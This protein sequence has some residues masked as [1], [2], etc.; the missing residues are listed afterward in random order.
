VQGVQE[1]PDYSKVSFPNMPALDLRLVL[2]AAHPQEVAF[3][4][5]L[6]ALDP[7]RRLGALEALQLDYF[8]SAPLPAPA[9]AV[10]VPL[11]IMGKAAHAGGGVGK[12]VA[13]V[14]SFLRDVVDTVVLEEFI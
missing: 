14:E 12:P 5:R 11:R 10:H 3:L 13:S 8:Q 9:A 7:S 6:L 2:P 4:S 1:L